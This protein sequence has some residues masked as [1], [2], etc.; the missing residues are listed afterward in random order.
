MSRGKVSRAASKGT[1]VGQSNRK[2]VRV[3]S[4]SSVVGSKGTGVSSSAGGAA[5]SS[6]TVCRQVRSGGSA[7]TKPGMKC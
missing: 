7:Q 5:R 4:R 3:Q 1:K 6:V 2:V